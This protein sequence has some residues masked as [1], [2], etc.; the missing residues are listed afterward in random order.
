M[1]KKLA[2]SIAAQAD[3]NSIASSSEVSVPQ[4]SLSIATMTHT[5]N[6]TPPPPNDCSTNGGESATEGGVSLQELVRKKRKFDDKHSSD[7]PQARDGPSN[8]LSPGQD[9]TIKKAKEG[10][11]SP[12]MRRVEDTLVVAE[13]DLIISRMKADGFGEYIGKGGDE[14]TI[15]RC[16][17]GRDYLFDFEKNGLKERRVRELKLMIDPKQKAIHERALL[18]VRLDGDVTN[19]TKPQPQKSNNDGVLVASKKL[20]GVTV[21]TTERDERGLQRDVANGIYQ[22]KYSVDRAA[23]KKVAESYGTED[24]DEEFSWN[25]FKDFGSK[26]IQRVQ[27]SGNCFVH[28]PA[29]LQSYLLQGNTSVQVIDICKFARHT[30]SSEKVS[31][32]IVAD[33]GGN[34]LDELK[35][36]LGK[37]RGKLQVYPYSDNLFKT[38]WKC[39]CDNKRQE[40]Y[41]RGCP[42]EMYH[43]LFT[44]GPI[45][46]HC[47]LT[48][49]AFKA[50][51]AMVDGNGNVDLP[52]FTGKVNVN[53]GGERHAM[54]LVG[55]RKK[56]ERSLGGSCSRTGGL[57]CS[58]WKLQVN[59]WK[60]AGLSLSRFNQSSSRFQKSSI[61]AT[62]LT[63]K[64][65]SLEW[66]QWHHLSMS[67]QVVTNV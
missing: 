21:T 50:K 36:M 17:Y 55:M 32:Y 16:M 26:F 42:N 30:F 65:K 44:H 4:L 56:K 48:D 60:A 23:W 5:K 18:F 51:Q 24:A 25:A 57:I 62:K 63:Q 66:I 31:N 22:P 14:E 2:W 40:S 58:L 37:K 47:F 11:Y 34:S 9:E 38:D 45:L 53:G 10:G 15:L 54:V 29:V 46:I 64:R 59:T 1:P 67:V 8:H 27:R 28:A 61:A 39:Q 33:G 49:E 52:L 35:T 3:D 41:N 12:P 43:D 19:H 13:D 7:T 20:K 6:D